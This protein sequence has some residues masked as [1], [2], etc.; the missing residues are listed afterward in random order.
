[1]RGTNSK[2]KKTRPEKHFFSA[3]KGEGKAAVGLKSSNPQKTNLGT[4]LNLHTVEEEAMCAGPS[5][6]QV[7]KGK[8]PAFLP[9]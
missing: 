4:I 1:M 3:V 8:T 9:S 6:S 7:T 2:N 5:F